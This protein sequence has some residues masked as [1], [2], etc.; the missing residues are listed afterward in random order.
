MKIKPTIAAIAAFLALAIPVTATA[1]SAD[2][3]SSAWRGGYGD[4]P[5]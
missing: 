5:T 1:M 2:P 3:V 4:W